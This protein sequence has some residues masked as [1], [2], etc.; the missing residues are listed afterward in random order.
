[1]CHNKNNKKA[2]T[3]LHTLLEQL[4]CPSNLDQNSRVVFPLVQRPPNSGVGQLAGSGNAK[5]KV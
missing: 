2:H 5:C 4:I 1:M 3:L